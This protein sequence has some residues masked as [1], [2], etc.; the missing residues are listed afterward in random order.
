MKG[1]IVLCVLAVLCANEIQW[2]DYAGGM[3]EI[4]ETKKPGVVLIYRPTCPACRMLNGIFE[5]SPSVAALAKDFV[6]IR[7]VDG[8][9]SF[10][11]AFR[12]GTLLT[13]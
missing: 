11:G 7:S 10:Q 8:S 12:G 13:I 6:M 4:L 1:V 5:K 3:E 9:E 2:R